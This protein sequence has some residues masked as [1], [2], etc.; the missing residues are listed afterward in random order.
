[1]QWKDIY[2][3]ELPHGENETRTNNVML[4]LKLVEKK[5]HRREKIVKV[6]TETNTTESNEK[7]KRV[8]E[9][10]SLF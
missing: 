5:E 7:I 1:M 10:K 9:S 8:D 6:R 3:G 4:Y 2:S